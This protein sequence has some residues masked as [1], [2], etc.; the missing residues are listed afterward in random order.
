MPMFNKPLSEYKRFMEELNNYNESLEYHIDYSTYNEE[1]DLFLEDA[2]L[3]KLK[4]LLG[5][6][7]YT[8]IYV[9]FKDK[10]A[11]K[12]KVGEK[13]VDGKKVPIMG[14]N[15]DLKLKS[16]KYLLDTYSE[17]PQALKDLIA[18]YRTKS[19][20]IK[21]AKKGAKYLGE[22][23]DYKCYFVFTYPAAKYYG[24]NTT[25]CITGRYEGKEEEG[26]KFFNDYIR[27][28]N[29]D[30]GYYFFLH[31]TNPRRKY[32]L[33]QNKDKEIKS[34][35]SALNNEITDRDNLPL[36]PIVE[37][38]P[39]LKEIYSEE[40]IDDPETNKYRDMYSLWH[41]IIT[42]ADFPLHKAKE[43]IRNI[44]EIIENDN[45]KDYD[46]DL[47]LIVD[48]YGNT[49]LHLACKNA[50]RELVEYLLKKGSSV[51]QRNDY[52][53]TCMHIIC[54]RHN[55]QGILDLILENGGK[56]DLNLKNNS[57][58]TP[59]TICAIDRSWALVKKLIKEG[60]DINI[61]INQIR[62]NGDYLLHDACSIGDKE[63]VELLLDRDAQIQVKNKDNRTPFD[64][65]CI[66]F[67]SNSKDILKL[68]LDHG[69]WRQYDGRMDK[70]SPEIKYSMEYNKELRD[71][72]EQYF[73]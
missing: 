57:G 25:W 66:K 71:L 15:P 49:P 39:E 50:N 58:L 36:F 55:L 48:D 22:N 14:E 41:D 28:E 11:P 44:K 61:P 17:N 6:D 12:I 63:L 33:L 10:I 51:H 24:E 35:W 30:G 43:S 40:D 1:L 5:D 67:N 54:Q 29:L 9:P 42:S 13:I 64:I 4:A 20:E 46:F 26:E 72:L 19:D 53:D 73:K 69:A 3:D 2:N 37:E 31:K 68:L 21:E 32:A 38:I 65:A 16:V 27:D 60:A 56:E 7:Y 8:N 47:N 59:L 45:Y 18:N 23:K 52:G 70:L 34:V 62:D